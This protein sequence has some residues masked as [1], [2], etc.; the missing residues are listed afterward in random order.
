MV[1]IR[2][3]HRHQIRLFG[4]EHLS[5]LGVGVGAQPVCLGG[6]ARGVTTD[7]GAQF[8][9]GTL[10]EYPSV[11]APPTART[12]NGDPQQFRIHR[13]SCSTTTFPVS[14]ARNSSKARSNSATGIRCVMTREM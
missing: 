5:N 1:L 10:A 8:G 2:Q 11:L 6:G 7:D 9:V 13:A 4:V 3:R 14:P 12:D